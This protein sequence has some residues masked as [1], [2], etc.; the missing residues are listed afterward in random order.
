MGV[1]GSPSLRRR[2]RL[3]AQGQILLIV[4]STTGTKAPHHATGA[5]RTQRSYHPLY[6]PTYGSTETPA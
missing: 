5:I 1:Q 4:Y 3:A 6:S 2:E